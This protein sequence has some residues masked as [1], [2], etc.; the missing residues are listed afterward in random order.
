MKTHL[1]K[2]SLGILIFLG[3]LLYLFPSCE[4]I[5]EATATDVKYDFPDAYFTLDSVS[6]LKAEKVLFSRTFTA[7]IDSILDANGGSLQ[8]VKYYVVRL[9]IVTPSWVTLNWL[10]SARATITPQG[11]SPIQIATA[12]NINSLERTV[13]FTLMNLDVASSVKVPFQLNIYGDMNS[14]LPV[15][16]IQMLVESGIKL[17]VSPL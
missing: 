4:K 1:S 9:S 7:N 12:T 5:K 16:T 10:S 15:K 8:N 13:D 6:L 2:I 17:S 3:I 11:K 14:P